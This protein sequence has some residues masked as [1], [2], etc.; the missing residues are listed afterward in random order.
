MPYEKISHIL[1]WAK[2]IQKCRA[3]FQF[4]IVWYAQVDL[5]IETGIYA[6]SG[7]QVSRQSRA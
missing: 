5:M 1:R 3:S 7:L 2:T 6:S 4:S